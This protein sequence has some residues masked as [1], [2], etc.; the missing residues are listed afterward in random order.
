V[1]SFQVPAYPP[2]SPS[3]SLEEVSCDNATPAN[4]FRPRRVGCVVWWFPAQV[5][6]RQSRHPSLASHVALAQ[7]SG[8]SGATFA[9]PLIEASLRIAVAVVSQCG[10]GRRG[11]WHGP[12]HETG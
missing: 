2:A 9:N 8:L 7:G 3:S 1:L 4:G 6:Y 12:W 5:I 10:N 11:A